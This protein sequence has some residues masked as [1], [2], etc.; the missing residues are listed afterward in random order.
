MGTVIGLFFLLICIFIPIPMYD[1]IAFYKKGLV[2]FHAEGKLA[3]SYF[4]GIGTD[5]LT[6]L[7]LKPTSF[8]F[9]GIGIVLFGLIHIGLP[10]LIALRFYYAQQRKS[11]E[12]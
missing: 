7:G 2:D 8:Q 4:F 9:K 6:V 1:G 10:A 3:L 5:K 12:E 11:T